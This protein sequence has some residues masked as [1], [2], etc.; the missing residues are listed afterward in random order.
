M[1]EVRKE[2]IRGH[3][4]QYTVHSKQYTE[5]K[6]TSTQSTITQYTSPQYTSTP[7]TSTQAHGTQAHSAQ[8]TVH[9]RYGTLT[10][11]PGVRG[12]QASDAC[13]GH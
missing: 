9:R 8:Q 13:A 5:H 6:Y 2:V 3:S 7:S 11:A 10:T 1:R 4:T 12:N